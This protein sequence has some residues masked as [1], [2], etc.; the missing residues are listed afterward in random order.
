MCSDCGGNRP[1]GILEWLVSNKTPAIGEVV[2]ILLKVFESDEDT[3]SFTWFIDGT[4]TDVTGDG[5]SYMPRELGIV[6]ITGEVSDPHGA[7]DTTTFTLEVQGGCP[8][9]NTVST[10]FG[11]QQAGC[12]QAPKI[13]FVGPTLWS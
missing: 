13:T 1:P 8:S 9:P 5:I 3:L 12:S 7:K 6:K 11:L 2:H 10:Q 4:L